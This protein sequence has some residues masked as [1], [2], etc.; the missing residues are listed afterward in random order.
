MGLAAGFEPPGGDSGSRRRCRPRGR[1]RRSKRVHFP[2]A[3]GLGQPPDRKRRRKSGGPAS[4]AIEPGD[5]GSSAG[6]YRFR[7]AFPRLHENGIV[8]ESW[9]VWIARFAESGVFLAA[10]VARRPMWSASACRCFG[11]GGLPPGSCGR[12]RGFVG[13]ANG[14]RGVGCRPPGGRKTAPASRLRDS[15]GKPSHST[16]PPPRLRPLPSR[17][18]TRWFGLL[19]ARTHG[20]P[21][22]SH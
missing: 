19:E 1:R 12:R 6:R 2:Y 18:P 9:V 15:E 5:G 13:L 3:A 10:G 21:A 22:V 7:G 16:C 17:H 8:P 4:T 11:Q 20:S 14:V